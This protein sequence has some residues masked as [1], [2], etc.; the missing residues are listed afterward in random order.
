MGNVMKNLSMRIY[1]SEFM[2]YVLDLDTILQA[3]TKI[4]LKR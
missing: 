3:R 1:R 2:Y 4:D